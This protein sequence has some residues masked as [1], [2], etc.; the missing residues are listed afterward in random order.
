M[1]M[2][3]AQGAF[4]N[5]LQTLILNG[6]NG[7]TQRK[8]KHPFDFMQPKVTYAFSLI[9]SRDSLPAISG[10]LVVKAISVTASSVWS[11]FIILRWFG[12]W[13]YRLKRVNTGGAP[14]FPPIVI[15]IF[16]LSLSLPPSLSLSL[17]LSVSLCIPGWIVWE[18]AACN[19]IWTGMM[20]QLRPCRARLPTQG[21]LHTYLQRRSKPQASFL[22]S[23][24]LLSQH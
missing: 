21:C 13:W 14:V 19:N 8:H 20:F 11:W 10:L 23:H 6:V 15:L 7:E 9:A 1:P 16:S 4:Q 3:W 12:W 22:P 18:T 5:A 17:C 2:A 24:G